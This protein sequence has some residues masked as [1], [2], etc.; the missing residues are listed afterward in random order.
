M[1]I[2][3]ELIINNKNQTLGNFNKHIIKIISEKI[4]I[5]LILYQVQTST[6]QQK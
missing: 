3:E 5:K 6:L 1:P 4:G 2:I